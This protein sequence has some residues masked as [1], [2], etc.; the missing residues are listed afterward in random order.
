MENILKIIVLF[1]LCSF[2]FS[3]AQEQK[4]EKFVID[5][6]Q[7]DIIV[8]DIVQD[9]IGYLWIATN[10]GLYQ[11]DGLSFTQKTT[12]NCKTVFTKKDTLFVGTKNKL[13]VIVDE[14][15]NSFESKAIQ[16]ISEI[17]NTIYL[18]TSKGI[19]IFKN[20][21]VETLQFKNKIDSSTINDILKIDHTIYIASN[22][23]LW[24]LKNLK[25]GK[26]IA[27]GN[28]KKLIENRKHIIATTRNGTIEVIMKDK[29]IKTIIT[30]TKI[31]NIYKVKD[32]RLLQGWTIQNLFKKQYY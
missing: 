18:A 32:V 6:N 29:N 22:S 23:G 14:R 5:K 21:S 20:N 4:I 17:N 10:L 12:S 7:K 1:I 3:V 28:F 2:N 9:D 24:S 11:Y 25:E 19:S 13:L 27:D 16:K 8:N 26:K 30:E 15:V 31:S